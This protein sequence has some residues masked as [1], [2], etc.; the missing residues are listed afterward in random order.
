MNADDAGLREALT[1]LADMWVQ[2]GTGEPC[3]T[4][5]EAQDVCAVQMLRVMGGDPAI[6]EPFLARRIATNRRILDSSSS[7]LRQAIEAQLNMWEAYDAEGYAAGDGPDP[8]SRIDRLRDVLAAHPAPTIRPYR[9]DAIALLHPDGWADIQPRW[10]T[11]TDLIPT[12]SSVDIERVR[13]LTDGGEPET[14]DPHPH[15]I[16][17]DGRLYVHDGHHRHLIALARQ[18]PTLQCRVVNE[19]G[20]TV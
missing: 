18:E 1:A 16:S 7:D 13:H 5:Q 17:H 15:V 3:T 20:E 2:Q 12:Q 9:T 19:N 11:V 8:C 4:A 6:G 10:V 14:G